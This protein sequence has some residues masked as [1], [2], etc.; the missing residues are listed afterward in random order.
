V[1][2]PKDAFI[3]NLWANPPL[4]PKRNI[5]R[6]TRVVATT[7]NARRTAA[8]A[9]SAPN[10]DAEAEIRSAGAFVLQLRQQDP[11]ERRAER[12]PRP[13]VL[14]IRAGMSLTD[15]GIQAITSATLPNAHQA[16]TPPPTIRGT[17]H[18]SLPIASSRPGNEKR[19]I[20]YAASMV[21]IES[22][23]MASTGWT[24][25]RGA[26][27]PRPT[28][29]RNIVQ[30]VTSDLSLAHSPLGGKWKNSDTRGGQRSS[31]EIEAGPHG[32]KCNCWVRRKGCGP[33]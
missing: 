6:D 12:R 20:S 22:Q 31:E 21:Q 26:R 7:H 24:A 28:L 5:L 23:S 4:R 25:R 1:Q 33:S 16:R 29:G 32:L 2:C 8:D 17:D 30:E 15:C 19:I 13:C 10:V 3:G 9:H 18:L 14:M 27:S 11:G